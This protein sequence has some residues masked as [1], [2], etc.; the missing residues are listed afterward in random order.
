MV[1][2]TF[3]NK[4]M[5]TFW[6]DILGKRVDHK[7]EPTLPKTIENSHET[8]FITGIRKIKLGKN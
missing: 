1:T 7:E 3:E 2:N 6:K 4:E 5:E 8:I